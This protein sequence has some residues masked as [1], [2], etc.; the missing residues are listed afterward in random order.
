[1]NAERGLS[2]LACEIDIFMYLHEHHPLVRGGNVMKNSILVLT[3]VGED[4]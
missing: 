4:T 1:M 2:D 3:K